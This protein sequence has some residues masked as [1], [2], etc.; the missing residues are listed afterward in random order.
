[1]RPHHPHPCAALSLSHLTSPH[2]HRRRRRG[3]RRRRCHG[4]QRQRQQR[5]HRR[6]RHLLRHQRRQR[7]ARRP[8]VGQ[9]WRA[10]GRPERHGRGLP[11][12]LDCRVVLILVIF[13]WWRDGGGGR[14]W[15]GH[16]VCGGGALKRGDGEG[17]GRERK[18]GEGRA[19]IPAFCFPCI[20]LSPHTYG[21]CPSFRVQARALRPP[22]HSRGPQRR[23]G[24]RGDGLCAPKRI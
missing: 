17:G 19:C 3:R 10:G 11:G 8:V 15:R 12:R 6:R 14:E 21:T 9:R 18:V 7:P 24:A 1:L 5:Q 20:F 13:W 2:T 23:G 22:P 4:Q 16:G